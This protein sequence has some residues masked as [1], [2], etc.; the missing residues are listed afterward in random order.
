MALQQNLLGVEL[1]WIRNAD[2]S[3]FRGIFP[4]AY[5][6]HSVLDSFVFIDEI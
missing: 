2:T 6:K 4:T 1:S 3:F 5:L